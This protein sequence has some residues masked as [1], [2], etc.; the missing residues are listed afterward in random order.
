MSILA[1]PGPGT[2]G[3]GSNRSEAH[4]KWEARPRLARGLRLTL[5]VAPFIASIAVCFVIGR[6][7]PPS[8]VGLHWAPWWI[9]LISLSVMT[10]R[11]TERL[12]RRLLPFAA[13]LDLTMVLPDRT[14]KRFSVAI[15]ATSTKALAREMEAG[16]HHDD[17]VAVVERFLALVTAIGNHD[18]RTRGHSER[19][20]AYSDILAEELGLSSGDR[21]QLRWAALVHDAGKLDVPSDILDK[22]GAPDDAEWDQ[23]RQH[24][25]SARVHLEPLRPWLGEWIRCGWEHHERWDGTGYPARL[26]GSDLHVG[27][28]IVAVADAYDVMTSVRSYKKSLP[29]STARQEIARNAGSQ[30]DPE[31]ARALMSASIGDLRKVTG[32]LGWFA[33]TL[34]AIG[35]L[36]FSQILGGLGATAAA[37][38][39]VLVA[40]SEAPPPLE[41]PAPVVVELEEDSESGAV[42]P[43]KLGPGQSFELTVP[44]THGSLVELGDGQKGWTYH[45]EPDTT[46]TDRLEYWLCEPDGRCVVGVASMEVTAIDDPTVVEPDSFSLDEDTL[47]IVALDDLLE[48]DYDVDDEL[49]VVSVSGGRLGVVQASSTAFTYRPRPNANGLD[50]LVYELS[51]GLTGRIAIEVVPIND[52]PTVTGPGNQETPIGT[53]LAPV[54]ASDIDGDELVFSA[55]GL[56][57]GLSMDPSTGAVSGSPA[58]GLGGRYP[59]AVTV[60]DGLAE[61]SIT[62]TVTVRP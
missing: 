52:P 37:S 20:R 11:S 57:S 28:R 13:L 16:D 14:P 18:R 49:T 22:A 10:I 7:M 5:V 50:Q 6:V 9:G 46:G 39:G 1:P 40:P 34:D 42:I 17:Q 38:A 32:P 62:I 25:V 43:V 53:D 41:V 2:S 21:E 8:R 15:R 60:S 51:T 44:P 26:T 19:V 31:V 4:T 59:V 3:D 45:P 27:S 30:F 54:T 33:G 36:P 47:L 56:P 48:N 24:P 12:G 58:T 23:L 29:A 61:A 55:A 35:R